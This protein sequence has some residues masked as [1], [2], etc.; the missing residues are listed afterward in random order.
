MTAFTFRPFP[1]WLREESVQQGMGK[2]QENEDRSKYFVYSYNIGNRG[3][4]S[5]SILGSALQSTAQCPTHPQNKHTTLQ[6]ASPH[7]FS[8]KH[9]HTLWHTQHYRKGQI[10]GVRKEEGGSLMGNT[11]YYISRQ[12]YRWQCALNVSTSRDSQQ[13]VAYTIRCAHQ[14][15]LHSLDVAVKTS[16]LTAIEDGWATNGDT[17]DVPKSSLKVL[18]FAKNALQ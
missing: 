1:E 12:I 10:H 6:F 14:T 4:C 7:S 8:T 5:N 13:T 16:R 17:C 15:W 3:Y 18:F 11:A 9:M 2:R